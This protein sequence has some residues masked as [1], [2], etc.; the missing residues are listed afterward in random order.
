MEQLLAPMLKPGDH[1]GFFSPSSPIT[2]H[3][4]KRFER[5]KQ[6]VRS[7]GLELVPGSLTGRSDSYRSGSPRARA[8]ELNVLLRDPRVRCVMSTI[9]GSN[10]NSMLPYID[11]DAIKR[12]PKV[13]V[14][15]SDVTALHA[16][17]HQ[18]TGLVTFYGPALVASLG[19]LEPLVSQT[20]D[21]FWALVGG[22]LEGSYE[23]PTPAGWTDEMLPWEEQTRA[24]QLLPNTVRALTPGRARGRLIGGN[25]N[26][27]SG[28]WATPY[29]WELRAGDILL[30]ED[31]LKDAA[32]VE[33]L[34]AHLHNTGALERVGGIILG[35]HEGFD[36]LG[37]GRAPVEIFEEIIG[38]PQVP[39][40]VDFDCSHTHPMMTLPLGAEVELDAD[41][42]K[43][44]VVEPVVC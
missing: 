5:A 24:K 19:E 31:S 43:V 39:M 12:A 42:V 38:A 13:F 20:W 27:M 35:K 10:S 8:E 7:R 28:L 26:T 11:Y 6:F 37:T 36:D 17:I 21:A 25:L 33:K 2:A 14:G 41:A 3:T 16:A 15:Y 29:Q 34:F 9:G 32:Q 30:I 22:P 23:L 44:R 18:R 40:I 1:V 4:P